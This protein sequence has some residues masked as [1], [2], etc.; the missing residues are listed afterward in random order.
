[1]IKRKEIMAEK[2]IS[3]KK[4]LS[5]LIEALD[6]LKKGE[7]IKYAIVPDAQM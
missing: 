3:G 5:R 2:L 6:L 7:G 4:P 1:M